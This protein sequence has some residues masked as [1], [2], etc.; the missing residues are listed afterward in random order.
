MGH[1]FLLAL[2]GIHVHGAE[3]E[4]AEASAVPADPF[5][6]EKYWAWGLFIDDRRNKDERDDGRQQAGQTTA[7]VDDPLYEQLPFR[8]HLD[9]CRQDGATVD[10]LYHLFGISL[11]T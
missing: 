10:F 6:R 11:D 7:D 3:F 4:D 9:A 5:L 1:Q 2:F 8:R